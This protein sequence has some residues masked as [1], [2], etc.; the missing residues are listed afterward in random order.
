MNR[1]IAFLLGLL[2]ASL[3]PAQAPEFSGRIKLFAS[4]FLA[5]NPQGG[6]FRHEA[7]DFACKRLEMRL[8][9]AGELS[10][11]VSYQARLDAYAYPGDLGQGVFP[12]A[13]ALGTAVASEHF[14]MSLHEASVKVADFLIPRLDL[15][16]GKQRIQWGSA[17]KL[18]VVDN[19]NPIDMANFFTFDPDFF[20]ERRPQTA[21]S[22]EYYFGRSGRLQLV[23]QPQNPLSPLPFGYSRTLARLG[24]L[25]EI[26]VKKYWGQRLDAVPFAARLS[27]SAA[28]MDFGLSYYNGNASLPALQELTLALNAAAV[29]YYPHLQVLGLDL[30]GEWQG[31][32]FWG[33]AALIVPE[34]VAG[35][36]HSPLA[37]NG[38]TILVENSFRLL[39]GHY[40][41]YVLGLDCTL[42]GGLYANLQFLHGFFDEWGF[43]AEAQRALGLGQGIFFG[44]ISDYLFGRLDYK[45]ADEKA[46]LKLSGLLEMTRSGTAPALLPEAEFRLADSLI[47]QLGAF[48]PATGREG[49]AKFALFRKDAMAYLGLKLDF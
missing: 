35:R 43:T 41:K 26:A 11:R 37:V 9:F 44:S 39:Q 22:L 16:V 47:V 24:G 21:L 12:E 49:G 3:A 25:Q 23:W 45:T 34:E 17:D 28:G 32:G 29:F 38:Q 27:A 5:S 46:R 1:P 2:L 48:W 31:I 33:E 8:R 42:G 14:E 4:T 36:L 7:L 15:T 20:G 10:E 6:F 30:A 18:N 19:L 40:W 13:G